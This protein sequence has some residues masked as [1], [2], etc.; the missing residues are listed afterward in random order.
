MKTNTVTGLILAGGRGKRMEGQDKGLI[1][2]NAETLVEHCI[3]RFAPQIDHLCISANRHIARYQ[4]LGYP[5]LADSS[6]DFLGPL[7]GLLSAYQQLQASLIAVVPCDA[8]L[9]ACDL[10][11]RLLDARAM[12]QDLAVIPHDGQRLQPL[13][14]LYTQKALAA[15]PAYLDSGQRKVL[16]WVESL[17]PRIVD[18]SDRQD[19]FHNVNSMTELDEVKFLLQHEAASTTKPS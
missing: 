17:A 13:F 7:A 11:S 9:L 1:P 12:E 6:D 10:V 18:F 4:Q 16:T 19:S 8:P 5:V 15:L 14:G 3:R 2:L